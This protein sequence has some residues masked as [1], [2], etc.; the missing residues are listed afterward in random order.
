[1]VV[2]LQL[3]FDKQ[4]SVEVSLGSF[5]MGQEWEIMGVVSPP[6]VKDD[7]IILRVF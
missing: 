4:C 3:V 2:Q 6:H 5:H 1:M 7:K